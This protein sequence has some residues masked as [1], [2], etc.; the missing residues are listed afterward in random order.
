MNKKLLTICVA[1][2]L[3]FSISA[4]H[5][6]DSNASDDATK[7]MESKSISVKVNWSD[8]VS[9]MPDYVK[10][11]LLRDGEI[12]DTAILNSTNSWSTTFSVV[13]DGNYQV[14]E[15]D[16]E[17]Y[18]V[19]VKGNADNG[20]VVINTLLSKE[21]LGAAGDGAADDNPDNDNQNDDNQDESDSKD[22]DDNPAAV[23][24][25]DDDNDADTQKNATNTTKDNKTDKNS[26]VPVNSTQNNDTGNNSSDN[27]D[28]KN[29][30]VKQVQKIIK[31]TTKVTTTKVNYKT[32]IPIVILVLA[33]I[34]AVLVPFAHRKDK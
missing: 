32:G 11:S 30:T 15:S 16:V 19:S 26:T 1:L 7:Q 24:T 34:A 3:L 28:V 6:E 13:D 10:I 20:F 23:V 5:A 22:N 31:H 21:V 12:V 25:A 18:S 33:S 27:D 17:G 8:N 9:D 14:K 29:S 2:F 4:I